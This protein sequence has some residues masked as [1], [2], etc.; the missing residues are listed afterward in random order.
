MQS[1]ARQGLFCES[2]PGMAHFKVVD[3]M[4]PPV[5]LNAYQC[6]KPSILVPLHQS[7]TLK[8][9][10][11]A[12]WVSHNTTFVFTHPYYYNI[13]LLPSFLNIFAF[14]LASSNSSQSLRGLRQ[15]W[16]ACTSLSTSTPTLPIHNRLPVTISYGH[17]GCQH[18]RR[19][20]RRLSRVP[21]P[22]LHRSMRATGHQIPGR[23]VLLSVEDTFYQEEEE[24]WR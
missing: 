20:Q 12:P 17:V 16:Q 8:Q 24:K 18:T 21:G 9:P 10:I 13:A 3:V 14:D 23:F 15:L 2:A 1:N 11:H 22:A 6:R 4:F 7:Q 19:C 5:K